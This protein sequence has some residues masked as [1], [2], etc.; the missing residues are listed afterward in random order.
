MSCGLKREPTW[1]LQDLESH[2]WLYKDV[3]GELSIWGNTSQALSLAEFAKRCRIGSAA[4]SDSKLPASCSPVEQMDLSQ[5]ES[6]SG[7][8]A[9]GGKDAEPSLQALRKYIEQA[10]FIDRSGVSDSGDTPDPTAPHEPAGESSYRALASQSRR[11]KAADGLLECCYS[12]PQEGR[13]WPRE[14]GD[15]SSALIRTGS[16]MGTPAEEVVGGD[17]ASAFMQT[18]SPLCGPTDSPMGTP[19][20]EVWL[21]SM[22]SGTGIPFGAQ[23]LTESC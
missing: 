15:A 23:P 13:P 18:G 22:L 5:P 3:E 7:R 10:S 16:P 4:A 11:Q 1:T 19:A 2:R 12:R 14:G 8:A 20:E 6:L 17:D 21:P 9:G